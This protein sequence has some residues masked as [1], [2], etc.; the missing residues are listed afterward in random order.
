VARVAPA[1]FAQRGF[2]IFRNEVCQRELEFCT[3]TSPAYRGFFLGIHHALIEAIINISA[4]AG[5][6]GL[7]YRQPKQGG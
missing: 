1:L 7:A 4:F 2:S 5:F 6:I 3:D